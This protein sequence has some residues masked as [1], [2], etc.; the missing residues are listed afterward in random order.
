MTRTRIINNSK[1]ADQTRNRVRIFRATHSILK[2]SFPSRSN[3]ALNQFTNLHNENVR[4][5]LADQLREWALEFNPRRRAVSSL[6]R[7][8]QSNGMNFLP[9]DSRTLLA[10][11]RSVVIVELAGGKF[12]DNGV[13]NALL[14]LFAGLKKSLKLNLCINIDGLPL[15]KSTTVGFWPILANI[16]SKLN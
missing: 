7:I 2:K 1:K 11:P 14:P 6:L 16:R 9:K 5:S 3:N 12:W 13:L 8:L 15:Y 4:K 10:T